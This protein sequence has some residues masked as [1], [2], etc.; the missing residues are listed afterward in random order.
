MRVVKPELFEKYR[1]LKIIDVHN[2]D[3]D[4]YVEKGS[5]EIWERFYIDKT[6]LFGAI[7]EPSAI[8]S[9]NLSWEAYRK[10]PTKFYPFFS[11]FPIYDHQGLTIVRENLEKGYYG[12]GETV[13]ASTYSPLTS[14]LQWKSLHPM[15]GNLPE[16]YKLCAEY[17]VPIL[18]HIDP[19]FGE[20]IDK[21]EE[22]LD[23][24]TETM[25]IFGHANVFNPPE[26]IE[27]LLIKHN[28]L[29]IDFFAG[30]TAYDPNNNY[31][32]DDY[33]PLIKRFPKQFLL[34]TDSATA[35]NLNY[36]KAINAMYEVI[37]L[38]NNEQIGELLGRKNFQY[39]IENQLPT[40][41]QLIIIEDQKEKIMEN[42][43]L[44]LLNKRMANE[45]IIKYKLNK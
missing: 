31:P 8:Q 20:V 16:I 37:D 9:D 24:F 6:V 36:E 5:M 34:S 21:L 29:Y 4:Y 26:N 39:M 18:L 33:I 3:A 35:S 10:Y 11:G 1:H 30:F 42:F 32:L 44:D 27:R 14:K 41:T 12:V 7:S 43:D 40:R 28:N 2:H 15:D 22:A 45:L 23:R 13:A 25:I 38:C 17:Q 19:P